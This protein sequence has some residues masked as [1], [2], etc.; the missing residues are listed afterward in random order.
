LHSSQNLCSQRTGLKQHR[1]RLIRVFKAF[2]QYTFGAGMA[3]A[4]TGS[5]IEPVTKP[6]HRCDAGI[7]RLPDLSVGDVI[8]YADDHRVPSFNP[9]IP[10]I[11]INYSAATVVRDA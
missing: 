9:L 5:D 7:D 11:S 8:A 1:L 2:A 10:L 6:N 3:F 4:A